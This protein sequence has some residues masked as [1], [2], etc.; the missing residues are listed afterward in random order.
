MRFTSQCGRASR[1]L[2]KHS[3]NETM[4]LNVLIHPE[5]HHQSLEHK[6]GGAGGV[7]PPDRAG[8]S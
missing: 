6:A 8:V 1:D 2:F 3:T 7:V 5:D 4:F